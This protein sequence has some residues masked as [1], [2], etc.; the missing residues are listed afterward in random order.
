VRNRLLKKVLVLVTIVIFN[1]VFVTMAIGINMSENL[2]LNNSPFKTPKD[3]GI[4]YWALLIGPWI[5]G[6]EPW[7]QNASSIS[8]EKM[9][10][11]LSS[12]NHW[13]KDHIKLITGKN[14]TK[15]NIIKGFRWL[16][17]MEGK[18][19]VVI[20]Y[21]ATHG[22]KLTFF[23]FPLDLPPFD[24]ADKSDEILATH[25][26]FKYPYLTYLRDDEIRFL[27]DQLESKGICL[28]V[29]SCSAGGFSEIADI[30]SLF[31]RG[32][33]MK[34]KGG[35]SFSAAFI[36]GFS[37]EIEGN[38]RV[39]LMASEEDEIAWA[40]PD[41]LDF[42]LELIKSLRKG[43]FDFNR[44]GFISAEEA[45]NFTQFKFNHQNP[46]I[47]DNY[48]GELDI[49]ISNYTIDFFDR[50][51]NNSRWT[52][53]D[54]AG[55]NGGDL[56]HISEI[57]CTSPTYCW[58]LGD[59]NTMR[60]NNNMNNSLVSPNI[61]IGVNPILTLFGRAARDY[62]DFL[63]IDVSSDNWNS[64][65]SDLL[66]FDQYDKYWDEKEIYLGDFDEETIQ[67]RFRVTTDEKIPYNPDE[68]KGFFM[69]DDIIIYS[70][71]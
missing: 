15:R 70:E 67:I 7:I 63:M 22:G 45:F 11:S 69:I 4:E 61:K 62:Y 9:Y 27:I 38:G 13:K 5:Y 39:I 24:E 8:A 37:E 17:G 66:W 59:E 19:D 44:N 2:S 41:G 16:D 50:C 64:Y 55:G 36:E 29:D 20:I 52:T 31:S 33:P 46:V 25:Y 49:T 3:S 51:S 48:D 14:A 57:D 71:Y 12:S 56:W 6:D 28:I 42:S 23:G 18:N 65:Q 53:I 21:F 1:Y 40:T 60:Y 10:N 34:Y 43:L 30:T 47:C 58:Y 26:S 54:H 35:N 32:N 68:G